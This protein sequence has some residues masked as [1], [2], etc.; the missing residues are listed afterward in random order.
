MA[1]TKKTAKKTAKKSA[2][3]KRTTS[4]GSSAKRGSSGKTTTS[5]NTI[6]NWTEKRGGHPATVKS[7]ARRGDAGV[8]RIDFPGYRGKDSLKEISWDEFFDKFDEKGLAFLYQEKT[9]SGK[10]SRF[11]KLVARDEKRSSAKRSGR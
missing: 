7:T 6:R 1:T 3:A 10:P 5:H 2:A 8:L 9:A 4:S 11:F